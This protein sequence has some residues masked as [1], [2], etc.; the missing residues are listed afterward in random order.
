M[1]T[2]IQQALLFPGIA[3]KLTALSHLYHNHGVTIIRGQGAT[4]TRNSVV[5]TTGTRIQ[6]HLL[7]RARIKVATS[8]LATGTAL[9]PGLTTWHCCYVRLSDSLLKLLARSEHLKDLE[10]ATQGR[11]E[12][13]AHATRA[14][15]CALPVAISAVGSSD[16]RA[17]GARAHRRALSQRTVSRRSPL[18]R[19][20]R[21]QVLS[22]TLGRGSRPQGSLAQYVLEQRIIYLSPAR[23]T[24]SEPFSVSRWLPSTSRASPSSA[25]APIDR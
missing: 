1:L 19:H 22:H 6:K 16:D 15:S 25:F 3:A 24:S 20:V 4:L 13:C 17:S 18:R 11:A 5:I 7:L 14:I 2:L 8:L 10:V 23:A 12:P 9:R 21:Q